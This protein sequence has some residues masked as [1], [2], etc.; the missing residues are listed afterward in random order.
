[1]SQYDPRP[2]VRSAYQHAF[3][4]TVFRRW[5]QRLGEGQLPTGARLQ[6]QGLKGKDSQQLFRACAACEFSFS[7]SVAF[8]LRLLLMLHG[9]RLTDLGRI[10]AVD[11]N[12]FIR[13]KALNRDW[14]STIPE[15][16]R[17][18]TACGADCVGK[19]DP[20][21]GLGAPPSTTKKGTLKTSQTHIVGVSQNRASPQNVGLPFWSPFEPTPKRAKPKNTPT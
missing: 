19:K 16:G 14:S 20:Q 4:R 2:E 6:T 1:M 3:S 17:F 8:L 21:L 15:G 18:R 13:A 5:L 10:C 11:E 9:K 7:S 12:V